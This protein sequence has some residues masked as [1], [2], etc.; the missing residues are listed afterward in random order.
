M[1][2]ALNR[3]QRLAEGNRFMDSAGP[4]RSYVRKQLNRFQPICFALAIVAKENICSG[5][6]IDP[7]REVAKAIYFY[8]LEEHLRILSRAFNN[9]R[10]DPNKNERHPDARF[11]VI[12]DRNI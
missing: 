9:S 7:A 10:G 5:G 1:H 8:R 12:I 4:K 2:D 6:E 3:S 11:I